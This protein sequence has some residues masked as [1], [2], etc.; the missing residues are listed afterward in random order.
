MSFICALPYY[1]MNRVVHNDAQLIYR[2]FR[3]I[4]LQ[5]LGNDTVIDQHN[6]TIRRQRSVI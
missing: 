6:T 5:R 1:I 4:P 2:L 3:L